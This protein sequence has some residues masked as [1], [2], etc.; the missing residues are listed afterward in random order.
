[1]S[2]LWTLQDFLA[3]TDGRPV[4]DM[5]EGITGISID[6]RTLKPG[7]AFFAIKGDNF[8]GHDFIGKA[9]S[10]GAAIAVVSE[11]RLVALGRWNMPLIVVRDV[12]EA[13]VQLGR[14]SR[15]R[16]KAQIVAITGSVGKTTTKDMMRTVLSASGK[17]HASVASFNNHWGVPLTL[18]RMPV[19]TRFGIFE[20]GMNHP[21]EITPL[22]AMVKPHVAM[23]T[24][25]APAHLGA[26]DSIEDIARAKAEIFNGI[27]PGGY[28]LLNRDNDHF[29]L[30]EKLAQRTGVEHIQSF[31]ATE[32]AEYRL[33][34]QTDFSR[35]Y[36]RWC[37]C[38]SQH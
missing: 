4:G 17:V 2:Y 28:V 35:R 11:D 32:G 22:V 5:P 10:A 12:L 1:M 36:R 8:D 33:I 38:Y 16:S 18:A 27:V 14:A 6:S 23:I 9:A 26:F 15:A 25:V 7:E 3:A 13:M 19:D 30:L 31:G 21:G 34:I 37:R 24:N 29:E 20:I